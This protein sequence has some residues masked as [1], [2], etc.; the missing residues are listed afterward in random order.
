MKF[1]QNYVSIQ[2]LDKKIEDLLEKLS[3]M[4]E[5]YAVMLEAQQL[6]ATVSD[7]NTTAVLDYITGII[8]KALSEL[9]PYDTRHIFLEKKLIRGEHAHIVVKLTNGE[10]V[11][12][13]LQLQ[14]GTGLRQIISFL[15]V[16]SLIEVRKGRR[17][18]LMD[19]LFSGLHPEAKSIVTDII[20]IFAEE[21]FQ[22]V[23]VEY[24]ANDIGKI[25]MV[26]KP[27][28]TAKVTPLESDKYND[29]VFVFHRPIEEIDRSIQVDEE[30]DIVEA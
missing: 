15:F 22:F 20:E 16:L 24:G 27:D 1:K 13:D 18:L 19:E 4:N 21:G 28:D 9:F 8:N 26:E 17:I 29:E 3:D 6:L 2:D 14:T 30:S 5:Q 25:Y 23:M 11:V 10:G 7:N 12:R